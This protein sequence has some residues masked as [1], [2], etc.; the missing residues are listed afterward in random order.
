MFSMMRGEIPSIMVSG[1]FAVPDGP[2][3]RMKLDL[4]DIVVGLERISV[5][6]CKIVFNEEANSAIQRDRSS[7]VVYFLHLL[8]IHLILALHHA[9]FLA[10]DAKRF[11]SNIDKWLA[12]ACRWGRPRG[13]WRRGGG[14]DFRGRRP[15]SRLL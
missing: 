7:H 1:L 15:V 3:S 5:P 2:A 13:R 8:S 4:E 11:S 14:G 9:P 10:T 12:W 6:A